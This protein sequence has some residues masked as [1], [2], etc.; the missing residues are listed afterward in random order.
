L[1]S[2]S[3]YRPKPKDCQSTPTNVPRRGIAIPN[4]FDQLLDQ[5][6]GRMQIGPASNG[7]VLHIE[8][9]ADHRR[10]IAHAV[11]RGRDPIPRND[12]MRRC[13]FTHTISLLTAFGSPAS[14]QA[15]GCEFNSRHEMRNLHRA[16]GRQMGSPSFSP[17]GK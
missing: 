16:T 6:L 7:A 13:A 14:R 10:E 2:N 1:A 9:L 4:G 8:R 11:P 12:Q 3:G 15:H 17:Y 5:D